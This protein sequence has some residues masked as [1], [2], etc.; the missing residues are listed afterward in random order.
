MK[1]KALIP[2]E[3]NIEHYAGEEISK[4]VM[5]GSEEIT[6][7]TDKKKVALWTKGAMERFDSL[8][9]EKTRIQIM[10]NWLKLC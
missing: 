8:V 1:H 2:I 3:K 5:E 4:K 9:D 6:E 10:N 7:K